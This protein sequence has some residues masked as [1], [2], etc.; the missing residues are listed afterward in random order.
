MLPL[1]AP[2]EMLY[3]VYLPSLSVKAIFPII[4]NNALGPPLRGLINESVTD[5]VAEGRGRLVD[6]SVTV[7]VMIPPVLSLVP[8]VT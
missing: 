2:G 5:T 1:K 3:I 7:P 4:I 6:E 8:K